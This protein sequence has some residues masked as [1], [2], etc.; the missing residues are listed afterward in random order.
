MHAT[1][2]TL[3]I[4]YNVGLHEYSVLRNCVSMDGAYI[5]RIKVQCITC[6]M[7]IMDY[8]LIVLQKFKII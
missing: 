5:L 7:Q 1:I 3:D 4:V 2:F 6:T 8:V